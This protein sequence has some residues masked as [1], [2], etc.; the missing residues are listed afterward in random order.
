MPNSPQTIGCPTPGRSGRFRPFAAALVFVSVAT[1]AL[2]A[3]TLTINVQGIG[4]TSGGPTPGSGAK[5]SVGEAVTITLR[6]ANGKVTGPVRLP[7]V[8]GLVLN[9]S[10]TNPGP[11][12]EE[13]NFFVTPTRGGAFAIPPFGI[14]TD[15]GQTLHVGAIKLRVVGQLPPSPSALVLPLLTRASSRAKSRGGEA[16]LTAPVRS[17]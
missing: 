2:A 5:I 9:G 11:H 8:D 15:D 12:S 13:F 17:S 14:R 7:A 6:V 1:T 10:G 16:A 4:Y 3:A